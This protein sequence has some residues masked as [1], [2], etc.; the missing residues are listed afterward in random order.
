MCG[1]V[2]VSANANRR[3]TTERLCD[4]S[5]MIKIDCI[6][7]P[8][9]VI[10]GDFQKPSR[11]YRSTHTEPEPEICSNVIV[12]PHVSPISNRGIQAME[13]LPPNDKG[14][15]KICFGGNHFAGLQN[16]I[17]E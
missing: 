6:A 12:N 13:N 2:K 4:T 16:A 17:G 14:C 11:D 15:R 8:V 3:R 7:N 1:I 9:Q 5:V 10:D